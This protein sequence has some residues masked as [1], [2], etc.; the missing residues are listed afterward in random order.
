M[1]NTTTNQTYD[2]VTRLDAFVWDSNNFDQDSLM[3]FA[4]NIMGNINSAFRDLDQH[5]RS[6]T[7]L[8][9]Q[10]NDNIAAG[11]GTS[12]D[13]DRIAQTGRALTD[14]QNAFDS[15]LTTLRSL[16]FSLAADDDAKATIRALFY[17]R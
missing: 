1:N 8:S 15:N 3:I 17:I 5:A 16:L 12:F 11:H 14:A 4:R 9:A 10:L 6:L 7:D 13:V 2:L